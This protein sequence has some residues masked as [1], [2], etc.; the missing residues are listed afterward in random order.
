MNWLI[1]TNVLSE[2]VRPRP[3]AHVLS[4]FE[5]VDRPAVSVITV[6]EM[7]FG[8]AWKPRPAPLHA[9]V[10]GLLDRCEI[11]PVTRVI[12][13]RAGTMR[14]NLQAEG[15]PRTPADMLIAATAQVHALTLVT[16]NARDF[17]GCRIPLFNPF[18]G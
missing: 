14:G 13:E 11:L 6:E 4:W 12:A 1:D 2:L 15:S 8:F 17:R 5:Q 10:S 18:E 16:R 3:N 9:F 7:E